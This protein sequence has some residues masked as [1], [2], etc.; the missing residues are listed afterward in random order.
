MTTRRDFFRRILT[1]GALASVLG[2]EAAAS[3]ARAMTQ[4]TDKMIIAPGTGRDTLVKE[5]PANLDATRLEPTPLEE[6]GTMGLE[7]HEVDLAAWRL[8]VGGKVKNRLEI[9]YQEILT[10]PVVE[11]K[12]LLVCPGVFVNQ[13][14]WKGVS[15]LPIL[16]TAQVGPEVNF[17]TFRGPRGRYAKTLRVPLEH[18]RPER[19]FLA[20]GVNGCTLPVKHGFPLRVVADGYYGYDWVKYVDSIEADVV[21]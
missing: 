21:P 17:V 12:V 3:L 7:D 4:E 18:L 10:Y 9:T 13:G 6:F 20:Y 14:I 15:V 2:Y 1:G 5:N 8:S 16:E 19:V 11:K